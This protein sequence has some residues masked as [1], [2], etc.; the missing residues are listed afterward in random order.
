MSIDD[1]VEGID[2]HIEQ[3]DSDAT[4]LIELTMRRDYCQAAI[5]SQMELD[6]IDNDRL[7]FSKVADA[8]VRGLHGVI[9][10][11]LLKMTH[12]KYVSEDIEFKK[13]FMAD[14]SKSMKT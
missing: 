14:F 1:S 2:F 9:I 10:E 7:L 12:S 13:D 4:V 8:F 5:F 11:Q 6:A 3:R